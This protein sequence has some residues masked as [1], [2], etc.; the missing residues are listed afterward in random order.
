[1]KL[2]LTLGLL[3][4]LALQAVAA[5]TEAPATDPPAEGEIYRSSMPIRLLMLRTP[6]SP[7]RWNLQKDKRDGGL[8]YGL[9]TMPCPPPLNFHRNLVRLKH[10]EGTF[11]QPDFPTATGGAMT[12]R[13]QTPGVQ[14]RTLSWGSSETY[15]LNSRNKSTPGAFH[16]LRKPKYVTDVSPMN[17]I[18]HTQLRETAL[19]ME[20]TSLLSRFPGRRRGINGQ[21]S[22][23]QFP[24]KVLIS[25]SLRV[26]SSIR[27]D[28]QSSP[29]KMKTFLMIAALLVSALGVAAAPTADGTPL[30]RANRGLGAPLDRP[31]ASRA[32]PSFQTE[33]AVYLIPTK[34]AL[35]ESLKRAV[36]SR[37]YDL[38]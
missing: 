19:W 31:A 32:P 1:M 25:S 10:G 3:A 37:R 2:S 30:D 11:V 35:S 8:R 14:P 12:L 28:A 20:P 15:S 36:S 38:L 23:A 13:D 7:G 5:P 34:S 9:N 17:G 6:V 22:L 4:F 26:S 16:R 21:P 24:N 29:P 18:S 33:Y 27:L